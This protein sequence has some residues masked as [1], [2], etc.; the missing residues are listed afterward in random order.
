MLS[1]TQRLLKETSE[2]KMSVQQRLIVYTF[3][4]SSGAFEASTLFC[5]HSNSQERRLINYLTDIT[6]R[7]D[8]RHS[9]VEICG[10][11]PGS[12]SNVTLFKIFGETVLVKKNV[13]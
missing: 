1:F 13:H 11:S 3:Q 5:S 4:T 8:Q 9:K 7:M 6:L 10:C 2:G 12:K